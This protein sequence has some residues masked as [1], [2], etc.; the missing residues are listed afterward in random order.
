GI[1]TGSATETFSYDPNSS[2]A[3]EALTVGQTLTDTFTYTV[4]DQH[5]DTSTATVT[6]FV[7][8]T[9]HVTASAASA[10]TNEDSAITITAAAS[11]D[12]DTTLTAFDKITGFSLGSTTSANG[13]TVSLVSNT[14]IGTNSADR[15]FSRMQNSSMVIASATVGQTLTDTFTYTVTDQHGDTST[16]TVTVFVSETD[17]VTA[18]AASA[19][20][21]EDSAI[22]ITAAAS[23]ARRSTELAF[24]KITGFSLGSTTSA[25]GA[26][27]S[28]VSNTGIGT[29]S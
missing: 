22:T 9:D 13:A 16:A 24:D 12:H 11:A 6:V 29:N 17:Q 15:T 18:S 14:G 27:V 25:N 23:P 7:S 28:L 26:T 10:S 20:T 5:G 8:E 2:T 3:F 1:G 19:S 4:T 21:N